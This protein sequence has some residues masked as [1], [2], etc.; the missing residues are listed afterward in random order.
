MRI[1]ASLIAIALS[2]AFIAHAQNIVLT[3][4]DGWADAQIRAQYTDLTDAGFDVV[5]SA[6]AENESGTGSDSATP[7]VLTEPCEYD[8]CPVGSPAEGYNASDP[9][10]NYVNSYPVDAVSY[11]IQ[12]LAPQFFDGA[13]PD[14]VVSGPN[15]GN[16][17]G[18][19]V[20]ESGT[21]GAACEASKL[22]IPATAFS[23]DTGAQV[24]YTTLESDPTA[25]SSESSW[26]YAALTVYYTQTILASGTSGSSLLPADVIVS[27]N[28][29]SIDDCADATDYKWVFSRNLASDD[30]TDYETCGS[31]TLPAESD[32]VATS[33]CYSSVTVLSITNK[34][35]VDAATQAEVYAALTALP[36][37]CLPS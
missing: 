27:V 15:I 7:T 34:T 20:L 37:S 29:P 21:V 33:G 4:D 13:G 3:N 6:P 1:S 28:Y 19:V 24:S 35:D 22:G 12:T 16:N 17:L 26:I 30:A 25:S 36:F 5:L 9:R 10:L 14:F 31:T 2:S 18:T 11:G 8:T 23:G 32:V